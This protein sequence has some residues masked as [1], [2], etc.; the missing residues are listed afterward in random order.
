MYI[1]QTCGNPSKLQDKTIDAFFR[2]VPM[3][4]KSKVQ[5]N[6]YFCHKFQFWKADIFFSSNPAWCQ[7]DSR[8]DL[9]HFICLIYSYNNKI[10]YR[11]L[12]VI[13]CKNQIKS[14]Y[15]PQWPLWLLKIFRESVFGHKSLSYAQIVSCLKSLNKFSTKL[16]CVLIDQQS[17][18]HLS[19]MRM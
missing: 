13:F 2:G 3:F 6:L 5:L 18:R 19:T 10:L 14:L 4:W 17:S 7:S 1:L 9:L 12:T 11:S 15:R 8:T 16:F